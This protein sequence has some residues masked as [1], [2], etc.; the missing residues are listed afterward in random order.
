MFSEKLQN[1]DV[2]W[3]QLMFFFTFMCNYFV[4]II[5]WGAID[6]IDLAEDRN[7]WRPLVNSVTNLQVP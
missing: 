5:G 3:L 4:F 1:I 6:W 2:H 7:H